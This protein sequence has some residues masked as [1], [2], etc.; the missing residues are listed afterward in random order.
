MG[1]NVC[2]PL[3]PEFK[4]YTKSALD[5]LQYRRECILN[6]IASVQQHF[7]QLYSSKE[8]QCKLG[9]ESSAS[10]DSFQLGQLLRFLISRKL[11]FLVDFSPVSLDTVP[12]TSMLEI[13]DLLA[14]LRQIPAYQVDKHHTNC[15]PRIRVEPVLEYIRAMLAANVISIP[16]ADWK[17]RRLD[18][19]W[20]AGKDPSMDAGEGNATFAFTRAMSNDG[21]LKME[22]NMYADKMA[23]KLFTAESWDWTPEV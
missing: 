4:H 22:G 13:E 9:Y 11:S 18:I 16:L 3:T 8:R 12:D 17:K 10:C 20:V 19:S 1:W 7:I 2:Y 15:G 21:R 23:K 5:E 6:T 14:T